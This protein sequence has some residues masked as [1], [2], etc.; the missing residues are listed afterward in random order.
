[1][2]EIEASAIPVISCFAAVVAAA[3]DISATVAG[4]AGRP[5]NSID[6]VAGLIY[7]LQTPMTSLENQ[8]YGDLAGRLMNDNTDESEDLTDAEAEHDGTESDPDVGCASPEF[9]D[10]LDYVEKDLTV[11]TYSCP[12][13]ICREVTACI[14]AHSSYVPED[15]QGHLFLNAIRHTCAAHHITVGGR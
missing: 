8:K 4:H 9:S 1:M 11:F 12:C 13:R 6:I 15:P 2:D 5:V 10:D 14:A 3:A 7:R